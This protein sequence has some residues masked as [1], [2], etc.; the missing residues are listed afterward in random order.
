[1]SFAPRTWNAGETVTDTMLNE[2]IRDQFNEIFA[3]WTS[4]TP[5]WTAATTNPSLGNGTLIGR[6]L[7]VGR[8]C[9]AHI[10]L[11][12]GSTTTYGS[13]NY[14]WALPFTS[15]NAGCTYIGHAHLLSGSTRWMGQFVISPNST[16][17]SPFFPAN[18]T[19]TTAAFMQQGAPV[20][21]ASGHQVRI[22]VQYETAS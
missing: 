20:T 3:A 8:T 2:E 18:S 12:T 7:K 1:M 17:A 5:T 21:L 14:A 22:T 16:T 4:Y 6:Y 10:N 13:G 15:A 19:T 11:V 9:T